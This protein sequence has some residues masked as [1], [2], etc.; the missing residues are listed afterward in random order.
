MTYKGKILVVDDTPDS[1]RLLTNLLTEEGYDVRSAISGEL[2]LRAATNNPPELVLLD[3]HMPK[4]DGYEVCRRLKADPATREVPVIFVSA[5]SETDEKVLGFDIGAV[6]YITKP[7]QRNEL[8]ARVRTHLDLNRLRHHLENLVDERTVELQQ[9]AEHYRQ[10]FDGATVA[11]ALADAETGEILDINHAM[12]RLTGW[13]KAELIGKPQNILHPPEPEAAPV[14]SSFAQHRADN[15]GERLETQLLTKEGTIR[16]VAIKASHLNL[17]GRSV[18]IGFFGDM[19]ERKASAARIER[20]T[21]LYRA[22]SEVNQAIVHCTSEAELFQKICCVAVEFGGI[23][24]AWVGLADNANKRVVPVASCGEGKEYLDGI[25]I[26]T[27]AGD[28]FGNGPTGSSIRENKPFW[29]HN[30]PQEPATAPW[31]ERVVIFGWKAAASLPLLRNG[32]VI[33]AFI[34]YANETNAFDEEARNLLVEMS[35]DVSFALDNFD[36]ETRREQAQQALLR[37]ES[38]FRAYFERSM[39]GMAASS[40]KKGWM[41]VNEALCTMLG[42][43]RDELMRLTWA[44]LT[45]PDDLATNEI[46]FNR[47]LSGKIEGYTMDKRFIRKEGTFIDVYLATRAVRHADGSLDYM[48]ALVEDITERKQHEAEII[49]AKERLST[50][51]DAIP[52]AVVF[53]DG[54]GRWLIANEPAK[55]SFQLHELPWQGKTEMELADLQPAFRAAHEGCRAGDEKAWQAGQ[56]LVGEEQMTDEKGRCAIIETRK[57][58]LFGKQGQRRGLAVIGRDITERRRAEMELRLY[59]RALDASTNSIVIV[60]ATHAEYPII[61]VNPAF[62]SVTG[63]SAEEALGQNPRFLQGSDRD[64]PELENIRSAVREKRNGQAVLRN[65]RK[66]GSLFWNELYISPVWGDSGEVT[67]FIGVERDIT[68]RKGYEAELA[69]MTNFDTLT[70][71]PNR[72]LFKDRLSQAIVHSHRSSGIIAVAVLDLDGF[73]LINDSL[74]HHIGDLLLQ[75]VAHRLSACVREVDTVSRLGGDE[76][77]IAMP[78]LTKAEDAVVIVEKLLQSIS[79]S[80]RCDMQDMYI[81]ASIGIAMHSQDGTDADSLLKHADLAMYRAKEQGRNRFQFY[82]PEMNLRVA[83]CLGLGNDLHRAL[84]HNEF[85]LHYQPQVDLQNGRIVG[86]EALL[87]WQHPVSGWM[88]PATFIPV[89]EHCGLIIPIGTWVLQQACLTAKAW[90]DRGFKIIMSVNLSA[91]QLREPGFVKLVQDALHTAGLEAHYLELELTEGILI[92]QAEFVFEVFRQLRQIGVGL[93]LDDFGTGYSSLSY[94]KRFPISRL[95]I[96]QSFICDIVKDPEDAAIVGAIIS[97]A[98][99]LKLKVIA[100]GVET[101]EQLAFLRKHHCDEIQGY[102]FSR[103]LPAADITVMLQQGKMLVPD[104][105]TGEQAP[106]LLLVDDE[107]NILNSLVRVLRRDGYRILKTTSAQ[108]ALG[109]LATNEVGVIVS[110]QRMP[111]MNGVEFLRRAKQLHPDSMRIVL[112][113]YTELQSVTDAINEGAVYKFL[114]KP[115]DDE[116]LRDQIREA[117]QRYEMKKERDALVTQLAAANDELSRAKLNLESRVD[118]KTLESLRN[119]D[120]LKVSQEVLECLPAGVIGV[121][122]D[123][124]IV[125]ANKQTQK[126]LGATAMMGSFAAESLPHALNELVQKAL[127][128]DLG[129]CDNWSNPQG[130]DFTCCS[131]RMGASSQARGVVLVLTQNGAQPG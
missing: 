87:R 53:K 42:Y 103:P 31:L 84:Q 14:S 119:M 25:Q 17:N 117:F 39:V 88:S 115:W 94:L 67:H 129:G 93:S 41:E 2:A 7:Y 40:S 125:I 66:D 50:L 5:A 20:L 80:M 33:G 23:N 98:R 38:H 63:Y 99:N 47:I 114:T 106:V 89:A 77:V 126:I 30:F 56:L 90:H 70:G 15:K 46:L 85:T 18:M 130:V 101:S 118:E 43:S 27:D 57:M 4:M 64:Q 10:L 104:E 108:E 62:T 6:D 112:S 97:M 109:M 113:G 60:D 124:M 75:E 28:P 52:D 48:V 21:K 12:E 16:P 3:I 32:V 72:N 81:T 96:D 122:E 13:D 19:T 69:R 82:A 131:H 8:M 105:N 107:E 73:K 44:E 110:D 11:I 111:E 86:V 92:E 24:M 49:A 54:E 1:L 59:G 83:E 76:F 123:G 68:Q 58:P 128:E 100:E 71:L 65:Y 37:S 102:Y 36:R 95:K 74:G 34:L 116:Q 78:E 51:L 9:S 22:L 61:Y 121:D 35:M 45:H 26:S 120:F 127:R 29:S 55:Q 79:A 91:R